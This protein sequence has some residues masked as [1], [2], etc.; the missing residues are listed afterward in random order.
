MPSL[1]ARNEVR[2]LEYTLVSTLKSSEKGDVQLVERGG[3]LYVRRYREISPELFSRIRGV[4]CPNVERLAE[5]SQDENGAYFV[6]E[7]IDGRKRA[8]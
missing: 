1:P 7:Y 6:G 3:R 5:R 2:T 8:A 4:S